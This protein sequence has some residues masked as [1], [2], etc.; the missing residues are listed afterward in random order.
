MAMQIGPKAMHKFEELNQKQTL[1]EWFVFKGINEG[2]S[3]GTRLTE[4][5]K[6]RA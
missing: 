2:K 5:S 3:R 6:N 4:L 1:F